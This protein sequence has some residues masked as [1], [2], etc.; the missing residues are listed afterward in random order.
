MRVQLK[1]ISEQVIVITGASSGIGLATARL[2]AKQGA[3]L[4]V[5]AR[6]GDDLS[7]L[8]QELEASGC[9]A[10]SI[11]ADVS[12]EAQV[13]RIAKVAIE[14]FGGFDTWVNNAGVS[15]YGDCLT[16]PVADMRRIFE[17][18]VWG[19]VHG[20]RVACEHL[21]QRG[22]ALINVG[23]E[24]SDK[25]V[26]LQGAY[27]ASKHAVKGWTDALRM[28][29]EQRSAPISVTLIKPGPIDTPY[30]QHA[31]NYLADKP[32]HAP[33]V[34][35]PESVAEA[36]LYAARTPV[37]DLFIGSGARMVA[38]MDRWAPRLT[39]RVVG[40]MVSRG[41]HS[42]RPVSGGDALY[43]PGGG[44]QERGDYEGMT[45]RSLYTSAAM[46]PVAAGAVAI[47]ATLLIG[48]WL[49]SGS[50]AGSGHSR[51]SHLN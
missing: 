14:R 6:S 35:R 17:T 24:V 49:R 48:S 51:H 15:V 28:E 25:A 45:R 42:G 33:P 36:I 22:G 21:L 34:Y 12:D 4:V 37:R 41:T 27:S 8:V 11:D 46:H 43:E 10:T 1:P 47:G 2:A 18:N 44:L 13:R 40:R 39:D 23:S 5:A 31:K 9:E 7:Q 50:D 32:T 20:S 29:L 30:T 16:V 26:P 3:K 19:V 38:A